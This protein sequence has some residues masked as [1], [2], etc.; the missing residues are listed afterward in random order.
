MFKFYDLHFIFKEKQLRK[1]KYNARD[2]AERNL[3]KLLFKN[4]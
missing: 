1:F 2:V 3:K 4:F